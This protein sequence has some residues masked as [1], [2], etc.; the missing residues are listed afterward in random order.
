MSPTGGPHKPQ[1]RSDLAAVALRGLDKT[2]HARRDEVLAVGT[3]TPRIERAG[4]DGPR[5]AEVRKDA[6]FASGRVCGHATAAAL[7]CA[8]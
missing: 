4:R 5:E 2:E 1:G 7:A 3:P 8:R 6:F